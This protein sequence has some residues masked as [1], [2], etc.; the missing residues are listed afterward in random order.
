MLVL[1]AGYG[2]SGASYWTSPPEEFA[3]ARCCNNPVMVPRNHPEFV[4]EQVVDVMEDYFK[5]ME[6][7][8]VRPI[9]GSEGRLETYP[10]VGST[11]LEPWRLDSVNFDE[12][13]ECTLQSIRRQAVVRVKMVEDGYMIDVAVYKQLEDMAEPQNAVAD[14]A[15]FSYSSTQVGVIDPITDEP[16]DIGWIPQGRDAALE[17]QILRDITGRLG[18][19]PTQSQCSATVSPP[20]CVP[21]EAAAG[22]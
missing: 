15:A 9:E 1:P 7:V 2:C 18:V 19:I 8:P 3:A 4:W 10:E 12:R 11:L 21:V 14:R 16:L 13:L 5:I 20:L 17:Q 6:E 22:R